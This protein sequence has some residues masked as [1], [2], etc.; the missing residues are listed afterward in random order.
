MFFR[1]GF[2]VHILMLKYWPSF[3]ENSLLFLLVEAVNVDLKLCK[4]IVHST[5]KQQHFALMRQNTTFLNLQWS[6]LHCRLDFQWW[7]LV[8]NVH[9]R[10]TT[11]RSRIL[12]SSSWY[13]TGN[14][15]LSRRTHLTFHRSQWTRS[16][17]RSSVSW[18]QSSQSLFKGE[19]SI[20]LHI[21]LFVDITSSCSFVSTWTPLIDK[22]LS[23]L[24]KPA[25]SAA[26]F[27][28]TLLRH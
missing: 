2:M 27:S 19:N 5:L 12:P 21:K 23:P 25:L 10:R 15:G 20:A 7:H 16:R 24:R 22:I 8:R 17:R 9:L 4:K 26:P 3:L 6:H 1:I 13:G 18:I 28:T 14:H 11:S